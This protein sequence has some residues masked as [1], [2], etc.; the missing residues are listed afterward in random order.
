MLSA[1]PPAPAHPVVASMRRVWNIPTRWSFSAA[2]GMAGVVW[3]SDTPG[4][5]FLAS[6]LPDDL[7]VVS[8]HSSTVGC[9]DVSLDDRSC[10]AGRL[11]RWS[12]MVVPSAGRPC[13]VTDGPFSLMHLY[14]P[15]PLLRARAEAYDVP[16]DTGRLDLCRHGEFSQA[17]LAATCRRILASGEQDGPLRRL[18]LDT[19]CDAALADLAALLVPAAAP[20]GPEALTPLQVRRLDEFLE[21]HLDEEMDLDRLAAV[22]GLSKFH[23]ARAFKAQFARSP[24][25]EVQARRLE[26]A[27]RLLARTRLPISEIAQS[28]GFSDQSHLTRSFRAAFGQTP[29]AYRTD[30]PPR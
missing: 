14:V 27:A 19:L 23:F 28:C 20:Q 10:F 18:A 1:D 12:W 2:N 9:A 17:P 6:D 8:L 22:A 25:R 5:R 11:N 30:A 7:L 3:H 13:A 24:M 29:G 4:E 26:R 21:A 15:L 16:L